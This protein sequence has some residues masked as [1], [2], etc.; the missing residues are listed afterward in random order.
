MARIRLCLLSA[1]RELER[2]VGQ[3]GDQFRLAAISLIAMPDDARIREGSELD[4]EAVR[5]RGDVRIRVIL[6]QRSVRKRRSISVFG[7]LLP[8]KGQRQR[9][10]QLVKRVRPLGDDVM[11]PDRADWVLVPTGV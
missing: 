3:L 10:A 1:R 11:I 7:Q 9:S 6:R 4:K 8:G 2:V 5:P